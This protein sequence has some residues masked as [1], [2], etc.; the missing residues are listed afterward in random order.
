VAT[1]KK[2]MSHGTEGNEEIE[3]ATEERQ[4]NTACEKSSYC[5]T[6]S[7]WYTTGRILTHLD[8]GRESPNEREWF[9]DSQTRRLYVDSYAVILMAWTQWTLYFRGPVTNAEIFELLAVEA[10]R[11][12]PPMTRAFRRAARR[13]HLWP[14]EATALIEQRRSLTELSGISPYIEKYIERWV[15]DPPPRTV[16]PRI[17]SGF[18][19]MT[20]AR[21]ALATTVDRLSVSHFLPVSVPSVV[22]GARM[23]DVNR[24]PVGSGICP[25]DAVV[26]MGRRNTQLEPTWHWKQKLKALARLDQPERY[27]G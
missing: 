2:E 24:Q 22:L 11:A 23:Y 4:K 10:E 17:R 26:S 19:T 12:R 16:T 13:A 1:P 25:F 21:A 18:L 5:Y 27:P 9:W 7:P 8:G 15:E 14:E 6:Q 20:E 3:Q